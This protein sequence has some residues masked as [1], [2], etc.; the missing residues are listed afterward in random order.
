MADQAEID[1]MLK[2]ELALS[3]KEEVSSENLPSQDEQSPPAAERAAASNATVAQQGIP[4]VDFYPQNTH[5]R[6]EQLVARLKEHQDNIRQ[7][8]LVKELF[9][10][11]TLEIKIHRSYYWNWV[12]EANK[13]LVNTV[14]LRARLRGLEKKYPK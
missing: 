5:K 11:R 9:K 8:L 10:L 2:G 12:R 3:S 1:E 4:W 6:P 14:R 7:M 13:I